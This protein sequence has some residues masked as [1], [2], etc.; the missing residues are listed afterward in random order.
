[1]TIPMAPADLWHDDMSC[2]RM[3]LPI[4]MEFVHVTILVPIVTQVTLVDNP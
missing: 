2:D 3:G 4:C 1:M